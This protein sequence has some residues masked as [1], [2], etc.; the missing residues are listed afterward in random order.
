MVYD[1]CRVANK[2]TTEVYQTDNCCDWQYNRGFWQSRTLVTLL[3]TGEILKGELTS[4]GFYCLL[5]Q[6]TIKSVR[7]LDAFDKTTKE[8][9]QMNCAVFLDDLTLKYHLDIH[10]NS[11]IHVQLRTRILGRF[12]IFLLY[13]STWYIYIYYTTKEQYQ[14][15]DEKW[16]YLD[17]TGHWNV[18]TIREFG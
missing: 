1:F 12:V 10:T 13:L 11:V 15:L 14:Q 18:T 3:D 6:P 16:S 17:K 8:R 7:H 9:L 2:S 5:S 4:Y